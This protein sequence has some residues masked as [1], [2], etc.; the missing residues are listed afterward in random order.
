MIKQLT[1]KNP[2]N[3]MQIIERYIDGIRFYKVTPNNLRAMVFEKIKQ[4]FADQ[5][6][7]IEISEDGWLKIEKTGRIETIEEEAKKKGVTM[8]MTAEEMLRKEA[9]M[10]KKQG[11]IVT[12]DKLK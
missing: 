11:F 2:L 4:Q 5:P 7:N 12:L 9:E 10:L 6:V 8:E 1:A 3:G